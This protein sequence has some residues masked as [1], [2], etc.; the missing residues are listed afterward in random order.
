MLVPDAWHDAQHAGY[1]RVAGQAWY[2][3][4]HSSS[5]SSSSS[6]PAVIQ[7]ALLLAVVR[8][9]AA[10]HGSVCA[11]AA[12]GA[13]RSIERNSAEGG[14]GPRAGKAA[15]WGEEGEKEGEE[16]LLSPSKRSFWAP[17]LRLSG[18]GTDTDTDMDMDV[19]MDIGTLLAQRCCLRET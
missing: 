5:S 2:A 14:S 9:A 1:N 12:V 19:D 8:A 18:A 4:G 3:L 11:H 17:R 6:P 16:L 10:E 13:P 7:H 15:K